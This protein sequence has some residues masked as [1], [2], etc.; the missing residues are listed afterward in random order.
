VTGK[1]KIQCWCIPKVVLLL[2]RPEEVDHVTGK[3]KIQCWCIPKVVLLLLL[4]RKMETML[5]LWYGHENS[6]L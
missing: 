4:L 6:C 3:T 5:C 1:T 2:R